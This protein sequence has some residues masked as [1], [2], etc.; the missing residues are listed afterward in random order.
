MPRGVVAGGRVMKTRMGGTLAFALMLPSLTRAQ[1]AS[2]P[3]QDLP[4]HITRLTLFGERADWS[5]DGTKIPFVEKT[6]GDAYEIDLE[7]KTGSP[8]NLHNTGRKALSGDSR[9]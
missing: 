3:D 4:P 9:G 7:T 1:H 6:F 2:S 5:H 8:Q